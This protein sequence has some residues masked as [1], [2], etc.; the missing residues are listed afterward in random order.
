MPIKEMRRRDYYQAKTRRTPVILRA[1]NRCWRGR[2][3]RICRPTLLFVHQFSGAAYEARSADR[4][5]LKVAALDD[6]T[7]T[8]TNTCGTLGLS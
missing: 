4:D 5:P 6:I 1:L 2:S 7:D 8:S 3:V